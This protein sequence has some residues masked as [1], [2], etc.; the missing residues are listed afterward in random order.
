VSLKL[1]LFLMHLLPDISVKLADV[2]V[3]L[4]QVSLHQLF[5]VGMFELRSA[6]VRPVHRT[7]EEPASWQELIEELFLDG[8]LLGSGYVL[9]LLQDSASSDL[10]TAE[11]EQVFEDTNPS[12]VEVPAVNEKDAVLVSDSS[13]AVLKST[14]T[15]LVPRD[16]QLVVLGV[17]FFIQDDSSDPLKHHCCLRRI[18]RG[19]ISLEHLP[20]LVHSGAH[21]SFWLHI[22][23]DSLKALLLSVVAFFFQVVHVSDS[24]G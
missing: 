6:F 4:V 2:V 13:R 7:I 24:F 20:L 8:P 10:R 14:E 23:F 12:D 17:I 19:N 18:I 21:D 15:N 5:K 11:L 16:N 9:T 1:F 3:D 22:G